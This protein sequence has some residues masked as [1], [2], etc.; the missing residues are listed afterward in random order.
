[1]FD[2]KTFK[3]IFFISDCFK[4]KGCGFTEWTWRK[5]KNI[6]KQ[7]NIPVGHLVVNRFITIC[8][9]HINYCIFAFGL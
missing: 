3:I 1:M 8:E 4:H 7:Y 9:E 6:N 2:E 5:N